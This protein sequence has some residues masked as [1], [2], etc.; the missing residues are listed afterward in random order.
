MFVNTDI[1]ELFD[2]YCDPSF[3][4]SC[5]KHDHVTDG[6]LKMD[7]RIQS[8]YSRKTGLVLSCGTVG[9]KH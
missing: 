4:V 5:V 2:E 8:N 9:M 3:A 6:G 7:G 1:S